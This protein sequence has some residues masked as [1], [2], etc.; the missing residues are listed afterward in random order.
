MAIVVDTTSLPGRVIVYD[1]VLGGLAIDYTNLY[2]RIAVALETISATLTNQINQNL[3]ILSANST[4]VSE[5]ITNI[6]NHFDTAGP[7]NN[8]AEQFKRLRDLGDKDIDGSG[9]RTYSPYQYIGNAILYQLYVKRAQILVE[10][11]ANQQDQLDALAKLEETVT[12][13]LTKLDP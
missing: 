13:L 9:I 1:D 10:P 4:T 6:D 7:D 5:K 3:D 11:E 8:L 2:D 12:E